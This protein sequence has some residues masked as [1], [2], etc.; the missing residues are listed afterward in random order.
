MHRGFCLELYPYGL[1]R[2]HG[3]VVFSNQDFSV[4]GVVKGM[5]V[6]LAP[7]TTPEAEKSR[8]EKKDYLKIEV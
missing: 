5:C 1:F 4:K 6:W 2:G 3:I 8:L 7:E